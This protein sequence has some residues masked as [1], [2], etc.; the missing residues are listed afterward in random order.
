MNGRLDGAAPRAFALTYLA[1]ESLGVVIFWIALATLP[2]LRAAFVPTGAPAGLLW[3]LAPAEA[4]LVA[5]GMLAIAGLTRR[6]IWVRGA[7]WL[8]AGA[9]LYASLLAVGLMLVEPRL[10]PGAGLMLPVLVVPLALAWAAVKTRA[11]TATPVWW[12]VLHTLVQVVFFWGFFLLIVPRLLLRV[13]VWLGVHADQFDATPV[14]ASGASL[15]TLASIAG[16]WSA[17]SMSA[18]GR[19]TPLPTSPA[20][21]LVIAGPYRCVRNPM[22]LAGVLQ[23]IGVGLW[24]GSWMVVAYALAGAVLWHL[25]VRP[26]EEQELL[27]RFGA[28]FDAYR[29][30]VRCWLPRPTSRP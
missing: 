8:H 28:E 27:E 1:I 4:G 21:R 5:T 18:I 29:R 12:C 17:W 13:E 16:L 20:Q 10:W 14:S 11:P 25:V 2:D 9:G 30:A 15:F 6:A 24:L 22:A 26:Q 7:L 3:S 23:V 19:G